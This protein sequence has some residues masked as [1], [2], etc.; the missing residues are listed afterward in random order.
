MITAGKTEDETEK[1][2]G[3]IL[4]A[5]ADPAIDNLNGEF[6]GDLLCQIVERPR[7]QVRVLGRSETPTI[8]T[9]VTLY[10]TGNNLIVKGDMVRR[11]LV[12]ELDTN[13]EQPELREFK[14]N[15]VDRVLADRGAYVAAVLTI[16]K[17]YLAA[18]CPDQG[19]DPLAS[20]DSWS[21]LVRSPLV[22]L[23]CA[24]P[25]LTQDRIREEDP[26]T[27]M[28]Q[29]IVR[30]WRD[31]VGVGVE[32][33]AAAS[34]LV[35]AAVRMHEDETKFHDALLAIGGA[36]GFGAAN[37]INVVAVGRWLG[38]REGEDHGRPKNHGDEGSQERSVQMVFRDDT[39]ST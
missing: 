4:F 8:E 31:A 16:A 7:V 27:Q 11:T 15:P 33:A 24:D 22:W 18:D 13:L 20:F 19:L 35:A 38:Q 26:E 23:G 39:S 29:R 32:H 10:A 36:R 34:D 14:D 37:T 9:R 6:E 5:V 21:K 1:R 28:L 3:S 25:K 2:L 12:A 30:S 17:A